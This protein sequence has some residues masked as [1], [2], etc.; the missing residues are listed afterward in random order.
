MTAPAR[1]TASAT[2]AAACRTER[3]RAATILALGGLLFGY[4]AVPPSHRKGVFPAHGPERENLST[5]GLTG[6]RAQPDNRTVN[7]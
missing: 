2:V 3:L 4:E 5:I 6:Y 7:E 1:G